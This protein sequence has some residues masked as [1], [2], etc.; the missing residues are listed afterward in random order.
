[1]EIR[2][3]L[4]HVLGYTCSH[5][6]YMSYEGSY[7]LTRGI[8]RWNN[9]DSTVTS[10]WLKLARLAQKIDTSVILCSVNIL[11]ALKRSFPLLSTLLCLSVLCFQAQ[12]LKILFNRKTAII[13]LYGKQK[14]TESLSLSR[15]TIFSLVSK[16]SNKNIYMEFELIPLQHSKPEQRSRLLD[17]VFCNHAILIALCSVLTKCTRYCG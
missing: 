14:V 2:V 3:P 16:E 17:T 9:V 12:S 13:I 7:R 15:E 5:V 11:I 8:R 10:S 4:K 1:M 6:S